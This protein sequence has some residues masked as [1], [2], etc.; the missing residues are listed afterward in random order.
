MRP[1]SE[2]GQLA[3]EI[4][5]NPPVQRRPV[6]PGPGGYLDNVSTIQD[7]PDCVQALLHH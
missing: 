3:G 2:S 1:V 5:G 6:H 7:C 4:P